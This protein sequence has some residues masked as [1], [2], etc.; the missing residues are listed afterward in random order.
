MEQIPKTLISAF[1]MMI[2]VRIGMGVI[3]CAL[4]AYGAADFANRNALSLAGYAYS[5]TEEQR[6]VGEGEARGYSVSVVR[7]DMDEDG[8]ADL[9]YV[10]VKYTLPV[11]FLEDGT[12][13]G[14]SC[15]Y[16]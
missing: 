11:P 5:D 10:S 4:S 16:A 2:F 12:I 15:A 13:E 7:E 1:L 6:I 8:S 3:G 14:Y 9:A